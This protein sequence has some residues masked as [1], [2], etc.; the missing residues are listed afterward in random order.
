MTDHAALVRRALSPAA[1]EEFDRRVREQGDRLADAIAAGAFDND[2]LTL[3]MELEAYAVDENCRLAELPADVFDPAAKELGLH[4]AEINAAPTPLSTAGIADQ[5]ETLAADLETTR[6]RAREHGLEIVLD[7]MWAVAPAEGTVEYLNDVE[8][9]R[10]ELAEEGTSTAE[11]PVVPG[12]DPDD[13]VVVA[14]NMRRDPRY[15]ALDNEALRRADGVLPFEVPGAT[16]DFYSILFESFATSIQ[17]HVQVPEVEAFPRYHNLATRTLGP[18]LALSTNS[19]FLPADCYDADADP[20]QVVEATHHE[21]RIAAFEQSM[22]QA[23]RKVRVPD[24]LSDSTDV[25]EHVV[26]DD[27]YA[28]FLAEWVG[29]GPADADA[30]SDERDAGDDPV[31]IADCWEFDYKR[32]TFWRWVRGVVCGDPVEGACNERSLRIEYRPLPTQP[33]VRDIVGIQVLTAGLLHG[34]ATSDHPLC[35]LP[36]AAA[37]RSFYA[38][39]ENGLD[40]DLAWMTADGERTDDHDAIF[41]EV[42]EYA[43]RGLDEQG[44]DRETQER[45]L[46]PIEA[47]VERGMTPSIWKKQQVQTAL[48][49]GATFEEALSAMQREYVRLSRERE[50]FADW[51]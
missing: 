22:N 10:G 47:R 3:G 34:L 41:T 23:C 45:Y 18:L 9:D 4:N 1:A 16:V 19:P 42:F 8:I 13:P 44:V 37:E 38:A 50:T 2:A 6:E 15:G 21:L 32:G 35:D 20:E 28:P 26:A 27:T 33:T 25:V 17:P 49:D 48:D 30:E 29:D 39:V 12:P 11:P 24:D 5:A 31:D 36:H 7:A 14:R 51:L 43:R 40:A 46:A